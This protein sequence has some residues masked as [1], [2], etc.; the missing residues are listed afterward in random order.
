VHG[1]KDLGKGLF[2]DILS[3]LGIDAD[4]FLDFMKNN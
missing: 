2:A 3:Q 1:G 4:D